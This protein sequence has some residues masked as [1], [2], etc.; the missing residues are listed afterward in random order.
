MRNRII[1]LLIILLT[2]GMHQVFG[3]ATLREAQRQ[4]ELL[5]YNE[6]ISLYEKAFEKKESLLAAKGLAESYRQLN[7]YQFAESW[8]AKVVQIDG[9]EPIDVFYYAEALRNNSKYTEAKEWYQK[10]QQEAGTE[11]LPNT[12][13][14]IASCDSAHNWMLKPVNFTFRLDTSLNTAESDW[15]AVPYKNGIVFTSDRILN[16]N[17]MKEN[18]FLFFNANNNLKK[19][20]TVGQ[21][22]PI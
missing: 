3:Q 13:K 9:H 6:A 21:V 8:Y 11:A 10:Y 2:F 7:N 16:A 18:R 5:N 12:N 14:L 1:Y 20:I 22:Y 4:T 15:G 19:V 17:Y